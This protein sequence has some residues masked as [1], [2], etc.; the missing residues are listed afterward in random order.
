MSPELVDFMFKFAGIF[1]VALTLTIIILSATGRKKVKSGFKSLT[2]ISSKVGKDA[3]KSG[4]KRYQKLKSKKPVLDNRQLP[5]GIREPNK[6]PLVNFSPQK[7]PKQEVIIPI[8]ETDNKHLY[9]EIPYQLIYTASCNGWQLG[10]VDPTNNKSI[11]FRCVGGWD[12]KLEVMK[13]WI[14]SPHYHKD[15]RKKE[16]YSLSNEGRIEKEYA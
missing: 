15:P 16:T 8:P 5:G 11:A 7:I 3:L 2:K 9:N 12:D 1:T 4:E 6:S 14:Y 10:D 13:V